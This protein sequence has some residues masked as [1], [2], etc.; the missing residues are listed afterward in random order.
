[1]LGFL[2]YK[3]KGLNSP[4]AL[5]FPQASTEMIPEA[6]RGPLLWYGAKTHKLDTF[7][8]TKQNKIVETGLFFPGDLATLYS[9]G[10]PLRIVFKSAS[11]VSKWYK[12]QVQLEGSSWFLQQADTALLSMF[13]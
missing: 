7:I 4:T 10:S 1:M 3:Q 5:D 6:W 8:E 9:T 2:S 13:P 12:S 11:S